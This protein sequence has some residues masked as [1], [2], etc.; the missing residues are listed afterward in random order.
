MSKAKPISWQEPEF[1]LILHTMLTML[2]HMICK[3]TLGTILS[4]NK[5]EIR[6]FVGFFPQ[7]YKVWKTEVSLLMSQ[8]VFWLSRRQQLGDVLLP[9]VSREKLAQQSGQSHGLKTVLECWPCCKSPMKSSECALKELPRSCV[10]ARSLKDPS[11]IF[12]RSGHPVP[13]V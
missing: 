6:G 10:T 12:W 8:E 3:W 1:R 13:M 2:V 7:S 11:A 5:A 9:F 4:C